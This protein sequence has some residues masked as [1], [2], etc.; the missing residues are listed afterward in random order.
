LASEPVPGWD[1][2]LV[3]VPEPGLA[4]ELVLAQALAHNQWLSMHQ[5]TLQRLED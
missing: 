1:L 3:L 5:L 4:L 2:E